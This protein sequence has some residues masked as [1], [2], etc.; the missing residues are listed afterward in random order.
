MLRGPRGRRHASRWCRPTSRPTTRWRSTPTASFSPTAPAIPPPSRPRSASSPTCSAAVPVFGICLGHQLLACALGARTFKLPFGHHGGNHPVQHLASGHVEITSQNHNYAV[1]A[2]TLPT[3][4]AD[5]DRD[6]PRQPERRR[7]RGFPL[8]VGPGLQRAVPPRGGTGPARRPL[9]LRRLPRPDGRGAVELPDGPECRG[10]PTSRR[11][12]SSAPAPSSS[13]RPASSTTPA[14]RPAG[15]CGP[16]ATVVVLANSNPATIMT[17]P[18]LADRTY[19]EPLDADTLSAIVER[20]RPDALLPTLGGQTGL[21]LAMALVERGVLDELRGRAHRRQRRGHRARPRTAT[22]SRRPWRRSVSR[23][24]RRDS[25]GRST[26]PWRWGS[27]SAS[28]S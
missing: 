24:R 22:S 20:E 23:C 6:H 15:C 8:H 25:P 19:V 26:R 10:G 16:R 11:S 13:A 1:D 28:P 5:G 9:P 14:P 21:N 17:D 18:E 7:G 3:T 27:G 2:A 12:W 4:G